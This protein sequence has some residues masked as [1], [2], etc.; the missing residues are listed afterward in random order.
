MATV[1]FGVVLSLVGLAMVVR[2]LR[3][4]RAVR[5]WTRT[6]GVVTSSRR[7]HLSE[8]NRQVWDL[9]V[10]YQDADGQV[11]RTYAR[12]VGDRVE[13][14]DGIE[15]AVWYDPRKPQSAV[16]ELPENADG[17]SWPIVLFGCV[18]AAAGVWIALFAR[19][20]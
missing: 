8:D 4:E 2:A 20:I 3:Q 18:L 13:S 6:T 19:R 15:V 16:V 9:E 12:L 17:R 7:A 10:D 1:A 5:Q 14:R 11:M